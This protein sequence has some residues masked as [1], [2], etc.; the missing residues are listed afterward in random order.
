MAYIVHAYDPVTGWS[1]VYEY[2]DGW[3]AAK[4]AQKLYDS[5]VEILQCAEDKQVSVDSLR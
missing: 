1:K 2:E 5:G 3:R 4:A